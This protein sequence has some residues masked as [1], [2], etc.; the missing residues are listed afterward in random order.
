MRFQNQYSELANHRALAVSLLWFPA[1]V[2]VLGSAGCTHNVTPRLP[3]VEVAKPIRADVPL[4]SEWI[5]TTVGYACDLLFEVDKWPFQTVVGKAKA[6]LVW[7][8]PN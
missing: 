8:V 6:Q 4:F 3:E 7:P 1:C 2:I 5:G